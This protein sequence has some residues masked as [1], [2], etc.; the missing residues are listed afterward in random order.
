VRQQ[1]AAGVQLLARRQGAGERNEAIPESLTAG[2]GPLT[3][4][5]EILERPFGGVKLIAHCREGGRIPIAEAL[6]KGGDALIL[7]GPEGDFTADEVELA[8]AN[9]FLPI[10]LGESRLR[11]ETAALVA[12]TAAYLNNN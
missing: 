5:R 3:P 7:I 2:V 12:V 9:G 8:L 4:V 6:P 1:R 11:T 10:S